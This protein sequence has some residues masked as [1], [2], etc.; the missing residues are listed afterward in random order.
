MSGKETDG[1]SMRET[2]NR[3]NF[4]SVFSSN[5]LDK[6]IRKIKKNN[7]KKNKTGN[8]MTLSLAY[9]R[10]KQERDGGRRNGV[11]RVGR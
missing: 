5:Q 6:W 9:V 2:T 10:Q 1:Q 7:L 8:G 3:Y 4:W 11:I